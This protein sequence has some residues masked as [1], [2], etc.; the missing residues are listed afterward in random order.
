MA[1]KK[2]RALGAL[3]ALLGL[4]STAAAQQSFYNLS[5]AQ[6]SPGVLLVREVVQYAHYRRDPVV[7]EFR[8]AMSETQLAY[9]LTPR[10]TVMGIVPLMYRD[11]GDE[12][13]GVDA[14]DFG[15]GD[16]HIMI[17]HRFWKRDTGPI[18]TMR[19]GLILGLD[20]PTGTDPFGNG[21]WDP[22]IGA[23]FTSIKDRHGFNAAARYKFN[24]DEEDDSLAR[25]SGDR[26]ADVLLLDLSYLYRIQPAMFTASSHGAWYLMADVNG[27]YETNGDAELRLSPGIMYE[28]RRWVIEAAVQLPLWSDLDHRGE[29]DYAI[30]LG[31]R[32]LF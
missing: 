26:L 28:A 22:M 18:D 27:I 16:A 24:T 31:F 12:P 21:G 13:A 20:I 7:G 23:V 10:T 2:L 29:L 8:L 17:K 3:A 5:A 25:Q 6:P 15:L 14:T 11:L 32:I 19:A 9:G 30:G 4:S 1:A